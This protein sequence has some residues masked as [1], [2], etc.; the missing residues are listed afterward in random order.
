MTSFHHGLIA[1]ILSLLLVCSLTAASFGSAAQ[2]RFISPDTLDPTLPGVGTNRYAYA[3]NDPIN[4]SDPNGHI[5]FLAPAIGW[6]CAGGG[7]EAVAMAI[8]GIATGTAIGVATFGNTLANEE[9]TPE[10]QEQGPRSLTTEEVKAFSEAGKSSSKGG[11]TEA[12]RAAEKHGSR[13]GSA[14]PQTH[15]V[16]ADI[17]KQGQRTL[18]D[19]LNDPGSTV[20]VDEAG[21]ITVTAPDGR[22]AQFRP[23]GKF[24]G[25]REPDDPR[26]SKEHQQQQQ[27]TTKKSL[28]SDHSEGH[29]SANTTHTMKP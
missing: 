4:K 21:R 12:G 10:D 2:A 25:F 26:L 3:A 1:R 15:G 24:K 20:S 9:A 17:N 19:I 16:A 27:N 28:D 6:A 7:C 11:R 13:A 29:D 18:D 22:G 14:F 8:L 5:A 23:D